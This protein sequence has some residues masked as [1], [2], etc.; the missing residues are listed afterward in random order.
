M[1]EAIG[2]RVLLKI[3]TEVKIKNKTILF[4]K[5]LVI[6]FVSSDNYT[7]L[8]LSDRGGIANAFHVLYP[9]K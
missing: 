2:I 4:Q 5:L 8:F 3:F 1:H 7:I 6:V 9:D